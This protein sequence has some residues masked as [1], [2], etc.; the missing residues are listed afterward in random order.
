[1]L[2]GTSHWRWARRVCRA[3]REGRPAASQGL[4]SRRPWRG[5][6][7]VGEAGVGGC[8]TGLGCRGDSTGS[9]RGCSGWN[10]GAGAC[11]LA[12]LRNGVGLVWKLSSS[13]QILVLAFQCAFAE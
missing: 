5:A 11:V 6:R 9:S 8:R 13:T 4:F 3:T 12:F 7:T 10:P 1:M 2:C